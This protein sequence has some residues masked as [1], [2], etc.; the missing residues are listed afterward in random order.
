MQSAFEQYL[1]NSDHFRDV[2]NTHRAATAEVLSVFLTLLRDQAHVPRPV[3]DD[4]LK[5]LEERGG[6]PSVIDERRLLIALIR[7]VLR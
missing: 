5:A 3:I 4:A 1:K 2:V 7:D 6:R